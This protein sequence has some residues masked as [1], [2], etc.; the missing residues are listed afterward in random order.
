MGHS[1]DTGKSPNQPE[2]EAL[3]TTE[4]KSLKENDQPNKEPEE[5]VEEEAETEETE[6]TTEET[7]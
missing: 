7:E 2:E 6:A 5:P 1:E 4:D 3:D